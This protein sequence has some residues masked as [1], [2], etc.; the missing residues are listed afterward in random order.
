MTIGPLGGRSMLHRPDGRRDR[1]ALYLRPLVNFSASQAGGDH[2]TGLST[3]RACSC[4]V[5]DEAI[6]YADVAAYLK[7]NLFAHDESASGNIC[8]Q[9]KGRC[10]ESRD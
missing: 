5:V 1:P 3:S 4:R 7:K 2:F 10:Y 6:C 8:K 9:I